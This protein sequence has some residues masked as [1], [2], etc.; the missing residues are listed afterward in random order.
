MQKH[1]KWLKSWQYS[2]ESTQ[3]P[4]ASENQ[5]D[6][7]LYYYGFQKSLHPFA[8]DESCLSIGRVKESISIFILRDKAAAMGASFYGTSTDLQPIFLLH[9]EKSKFL[10]WHCTIQLSDIHNKPV[11]CRLGFQWVL[12]WPFPVFLPYKPPVTQLLSQHS[13]R[14]TNTAATFSQKSSQICLPSAFP[15]FHACPL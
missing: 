13:I 9:L 7:G 1:E 14:H 10:L 12:E 4:L 2:S 3:Q 15:I 11:W 5:Q 8:L 6:Q